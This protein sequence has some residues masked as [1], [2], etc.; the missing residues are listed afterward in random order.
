LKKKSAQFLK[1]K[2]AK[3]LKF[4][5]ILKVF[6]QKTSTMAKARI[7]SISLPP[8]THSKKFLRMV[9][10]TGLVISG[11]YFAWQTYSMQQNQVVPVNMKSFQMNPQHET[12]YLDLPYHKSTIFLPMDSVEARN[13]IKSMIPKHL[14]KPWKLLHQANEVRNV[15]N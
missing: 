11:S 2:F 13:E 15:L 5:S 1:N 3:P 7:R 8:V 12:D 4:F 10:T 6:K 9:G 14:R